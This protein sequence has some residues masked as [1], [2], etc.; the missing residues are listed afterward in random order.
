MSMA[1]LFVMNVNDAVAPTTGARELRVPSFFEWVGDLF[2]RANQS[3]ID[4]EVEALI[5]HNG[6]RLTDDLERELS[7]RFGA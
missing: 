1:K 6:G 2:H 5:R 4:R 7:R 3:A